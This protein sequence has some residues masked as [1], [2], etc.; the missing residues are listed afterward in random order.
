M[1]G[2]KHVFDPKN[3][4]NPGKVFETTQEEQAHKENVALPMEL[5]AR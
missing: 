1:V 2:I 5:V 4:L 3:L